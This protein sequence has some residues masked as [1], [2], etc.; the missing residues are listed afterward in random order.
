[1]KTAKMLLVLGMLVTS[2]M[3]A[4]V[5]VADTFSDAE[6]LVNDTM[7]DCRD[8]K[9]LNSEEVE[10]LV[11][12]I[13]DADEDERQAVG[14]DASGRVKD[15]VKREYDKLERQKNDAIAL[16][17]K[18]LADSQYKDKHSKAKD[19]KD[20]LLDTWKSTEKLTQAVRAANHPVVN[21]MLEAGNRAHKE[22]QS[23]SSNC[24]V[25]EW[26]LPGSLRVDCLKA[27]SCEIIEIKPNN[28]RAEN[29]GWRQVKEYAKII[30]GTPKE[31]EKLAGKSAAFK[32][33]F[34]G[35]K[36]LK[37]HL[38]LYTFCP[39]IDDEGNYRSTSY[40]WNKK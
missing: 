16:L 10:R 26:E 30:D 22:Y 23:S 32:D 33:C 3:L 8:I 9:R 24:T 29:K 17:D 6:R 40:R 1:M 36:K 15:T 2:I 5:S 13:C 21:Y 35:G 4:Q 14:R 11:K 7:N 31:Q 25:S 37:T 19:Y 20:K 27:T 28:S 18:V 39:D 34:E 12:A 38:A